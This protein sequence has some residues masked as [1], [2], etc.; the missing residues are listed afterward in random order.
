MST[1]LT[2]IEFKLADGKVST[3]KDFSG[4]V[5]LVVNVASE[6]GLT[7]QY[8]GLEAIYEK[9]NAKALKIIL[10]QILTGNCITKLEKI[11]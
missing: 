9:Y 10:I 8:E 6:C 5:V 1:N 2:N 3:L 11:I 7:P 4:K